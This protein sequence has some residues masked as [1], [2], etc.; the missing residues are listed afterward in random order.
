MHEHVKILP[1]IHVKM[2]LEAN[3]NT[4]KENGTEFNQEN[5]KILHKNKFSPTLSKMNPTYENLE[6]KA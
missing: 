3:T 5:Q 1:K 6:S 2:L 4:I